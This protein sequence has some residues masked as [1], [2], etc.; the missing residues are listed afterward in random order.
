MVRIRRVFEFYLNSHIHV[1]LAVCS[2]SLITQLIFELEI[3]KNLLVFTFFGTISG[4]NFVKYFGLARFHH[5]RLAPWLRHI[6]IF[7]LLCFICLILVA[8]RLE[9]R[10]LVYYGM[11][12]IITFFYA[13]PFLPR[14]YL[15]DKAKNLRRISGLKIYVIV[16]VWTAVGVWIPYLNSGNQVSF[17]LIIMTLQIAIYVF[18]ATLPFEIRDLQ[19]DSIKLATIPQRIG[20]QST[21]VLG[22]V[23]LG[24]FILIQFLKDDINLTDSLILIVISLISLVFLWLSTVRQ[25]RY[26]SA[27]WVEAIPIFWLLLTIRFS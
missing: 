23:L 11:V 18:V 14:H 26:Y 12:G 19:F 9:F 17:D 13:I 25:G 20:V 21:K 7:A 6:Q 27:F 10:T 22:T 16:M 3:D 8:F 1:A 4:Y 5:K 2:L 15:I 24:A